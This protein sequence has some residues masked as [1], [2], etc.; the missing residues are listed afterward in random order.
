MFI[1]S[2]GSYLKQFYK[3]YLSSSVTPSGIGSIVP[4]PILSIAV[5]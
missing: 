4:E 2:V 1:L 5:I 3:N